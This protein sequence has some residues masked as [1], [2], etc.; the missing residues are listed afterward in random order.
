[1]LSVIYFNTKN[2]IPHKIFLRNNLKVYRNYLNTITLGTNNTV[3]QIIILR[4]KGVL[5]FRISSQ[6][7]KYTIVMRKK[8][9]CFL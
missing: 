3:P 8:E 9:Y 2:I 7:Y 4:K 6:I 1:M 5:Y